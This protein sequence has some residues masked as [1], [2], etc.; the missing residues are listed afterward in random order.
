M[1]LDILNKPA[2]RV[3]WRKRYGKPNKKKWGS[4]E[5]LWLTKIVTKIFGKFVMMMI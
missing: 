2:N 3:I 1:G 5:G 4:N